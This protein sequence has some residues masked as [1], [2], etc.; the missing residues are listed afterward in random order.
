MPKQGDIVIYI[1]EVDTD[2]SYSPNTGPAIVTKVNGDFS[3]DLMVFSMNGS[4]FKQGVK[5][6]DSVTRETWY[7]KCEQGD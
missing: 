4:F 5:K 3:L 6:G 2:D 7:P 1:M